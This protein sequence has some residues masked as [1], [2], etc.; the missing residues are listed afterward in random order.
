MDQWL[1]YADYQLEYSFTDAVTYLAK[2]SKA[3]KG[4]FV[5][6]MYFLLFVLSLYNYNIYNETSGV[7]LLFRITGQTN[8]KLD[9]I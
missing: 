9:I 8:I 7:F 5:I 1:K 3:T 6:E 2:F 4:I